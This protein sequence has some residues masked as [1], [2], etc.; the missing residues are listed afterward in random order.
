MMQFVSAPKVVTRLRQ[1]SEP[2]QQGGEIRPVFLRD[3]RKFQAHTCRRL[4][5]PHDSF[6]PYLPFFHKK[7]DLRVRPYRGRLLHF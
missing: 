4:H 2:R 7:I 5:V 3:R 1:S 6:R